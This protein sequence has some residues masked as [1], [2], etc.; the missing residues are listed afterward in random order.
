VQ[1]HKSYWVFVFFGKV[2]SGWGRAANTGVI[3]GKGGK[4][5]RLDIAT[6][7]LLAGQGT[8][9][10]APPPNKPNKAGGGGGER[11]GMGK[12]S[13]CKEHQTTE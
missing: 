9:K 8:I 6:G 2:W 7:G 3:R 10:E 12:Q 13:N 1:V 4:D 5:T 11:K